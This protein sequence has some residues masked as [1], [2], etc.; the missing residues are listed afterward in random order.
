MCHTAI[1]EYV[2]WTQNVHNSY[3]DN[4]GIP[5][6]KKHLQLLS[7]GTKLYYLW[8]K[9]FFDVRREI[10]NLSMLTFPSAPHYMRHPPQ[11]L[12]EPLKVNRLLQTLKLNSLIFL[13]S[14]K[15]S[16]H[17]SGAWCHSHPPVT[18]S[19][20]DFYF[21]ISE[22]HILPARVWTPA[23][24]LHLTNPCAKQKVLS[25]TKP[26]AR[27]LNEIPRPLYY[28]WSTPS[29]PLLPGSLWP[30]IVAPDRTLS[31]G[32]IELNCILMLNR[33][34]WIRTVWLNWIA[35]SRNIFDN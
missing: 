27:Y 22:W 2:K 35:W 17:A 32:W 7:S 19:I 3:I 34:V 12:S 13:K 33:I 10:H 18:F 16:V 8:V 5:K 1:C 25:L 9:R 21:D 23:L 28:M 6:H 24:M 26:K 30:G 11:G 31:M 14:P 20:R 15:S 29:L 4:L